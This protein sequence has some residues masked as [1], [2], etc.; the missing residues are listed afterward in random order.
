MATL[1]LL[2]MIASS[3]VSSIFTPSSF[4]R[5][6]PNSSMNAPRMPLPS[7]REMAVMSRTASKPSASAPAP[8]SMTA[9]SSAAPILRIFLLLLMLFMMLSPYS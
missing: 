2:E 9:A 4:F 3:V 8:V 7:S 5:S 6:I 1:V